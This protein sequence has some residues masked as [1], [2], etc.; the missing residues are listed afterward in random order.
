MTSIILALSGS[1]QLNHRFYYS[2]FVY[3]VFNVR[4][5]VLQKG[6]N[7]DLFRGSCVVDNKIR[8]VSV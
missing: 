1:N 8:I 7:V 4:K 3:S 2:F 5:D 6:K